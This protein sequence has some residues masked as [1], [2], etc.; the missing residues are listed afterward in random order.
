MS[1]ALLLIFAL[2]F[3]LSSNNIY[4]QDIVDDISDVDSGMGA[5]AEL[6]TET[7]RIISRSQ[8]IFIITNTNQMMNKGDFVT[9]VLN[10]SD[11]VARTLVAKNHEGLT[12]IKILKIYSLKRWALMRKNLDIQLLKGDDSKLFNKKKKKKS[13]GPSEE[14]VKIEGEEDLYNDKTLF[15]DDVGFLNKDNRHIKPDNIVGGA[16]GQFRFTNTIGADPTSGD[17]D[18]ISTNTFYGHWAFQFADNYWIEGVYGRTMINDFPAKQTQTLLNNFVG[19]F[20]YVFKAPLYSYIMPYIGFQSVSVS[21]PDAGRTTDATRA[22]QEEDIVN[23]LAK[24]GVVGG[25][26]ILKRM[27]PGWFA[28]ADLGTDAI[29]FGVAIEF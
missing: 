22:A 29:N 21:S 27:V 7:I 28:K 25:V 10:D 20:K 19:R 1:K 2:F 12:G 8:R 5:D 15:D 13:E 24:S 23:S 16:W 9:I 18:V 3:A 11:P 6:F 17:E 26:T 4:S 14:E